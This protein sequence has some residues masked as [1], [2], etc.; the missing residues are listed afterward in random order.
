MCGK[1]RVVEISGSNKSDKA[2][3]CVVVATTTPNK[4]K[5]RTAM[6]VVDSD[7]ERREAEEGGVVR[8]S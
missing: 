8:G 7:K 6:A 1:N 3:E 5:A 2:N 4:V